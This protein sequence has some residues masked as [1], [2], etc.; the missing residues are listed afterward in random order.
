VE[1]KGSTCRFQLGTRTNALK[2][3]HQFTEIFTE[4][5]RKSV[6]ITH[7]V[8]GQ[9]PRVTYTPGMKASLAQQAAVAAQQQQQPAVAAAAGGTATAAAAGQQQASILVRKQLL[10][11]VSVQPAQATAQVWFF[12]TFF[13]RAEILESCRVDINGSQCRKINAWMHKS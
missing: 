3:I 12:A 9:T 7:K 1:K 10:T 11:P 4:E 13:G 8:P 2:Y 5:G 6:K